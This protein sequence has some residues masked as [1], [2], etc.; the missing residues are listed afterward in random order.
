MAYASTSKSRL[1][2]TFSKN[3]IE[4]EFQLASSKVYV[5]RYNCFEYIVTAYAW[6]K[7]F[8]SRSGFYLLFLKKQT[9]A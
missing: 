3:D 4:Y 2:E 5:K 6:S 9:I 1:D 8:I 7:I